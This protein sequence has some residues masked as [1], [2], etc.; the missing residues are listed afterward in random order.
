MDTVLEIK[1][2]GM[3]YD[4]T[5][6]SVSAVDNV[7]FRIMNGEAMGLVGASGCGKTSL[8]MCIMK[9]LPEK[10]RRLKKKFY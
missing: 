5:E 7:S 9:L 10:I 1:N 2:L 3:S 4:T 8:G 6:G